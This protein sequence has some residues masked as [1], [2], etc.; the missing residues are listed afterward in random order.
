MSLFIIPSQSV[1]GKCVAKPLAKAFRKTS[2]VFTF[3]GINEKSV[4]MRVIRTWS[5]TDMT[6]LADDSLGTFLLIALNNQVELD[7]N[8]P[9]LYP[10]V[11]HLTMIY[12]C[13]KI[14]TFFQTTSSKQR[15]EVKTCTFFQ[16]IVCEI[17]HQ[18]DINISWC[19]FVKE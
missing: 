17:S 10:A 18:T 19:I 11:S 8:S 1:F 5:G 4:S 15:D 14:V 9:H 7:Q 3:A 13:R 2:N 12:F 6:P 16:K